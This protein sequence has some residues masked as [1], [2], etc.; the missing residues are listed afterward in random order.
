MWQAVLD[1][2]LRALMR[3]GSLVVHYPDGSVRH[4]GQDGS[5]PPSIRLR[6]IDTVRRI[7]L[8]PQ[9]A[10]GETY[11]DG[12]LTI[13]GDDLHGL[14]R[15]V[16]LGTGADRPAAWLAARQ[17]VERGVRR[18]GQLNR[19]PAARANV[20][21]HYDLPPAL[22]DLLLDED[23]QYSCGYFRSPDDSLE[24]AQAQKKAHIARKLL[25]EPGMTVLDIGCGWGASR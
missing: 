5:P 1:R 7:V 8:F 3:Q 17:L 19:R 11:M 4:Y 9:L 18:W 12:G 13:E 24:Q 21:H 2:M 15:S 6:D 25:L 10:L 16:I 20:Q 14:L 22:Y 23:R